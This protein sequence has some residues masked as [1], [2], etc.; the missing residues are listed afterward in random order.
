MRMTKRTGPTNTYLRELIVGLRKA[1]KKN[2]AAVW[3]DVAEKLENPRRQ[4]VEVD[5]VNIERHGEKGETV[6]VPGSVLG[7]GELTKPLTIA[8]WRFS[9]S[10]K[11]KIKKA[12]GHAISISELLTKN[13]K[14]EKVRIMV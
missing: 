9:E 6:V 12:D 2:Q 11:E 14:G 3:S 10:A 7:N 13:P 1:A 5:I 4:R 8:A